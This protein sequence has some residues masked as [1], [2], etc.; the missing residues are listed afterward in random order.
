MARGKS[1]GTCEHCQSQ[2]RYH[3]VHSGFNDSIY[4][5]CNTCG[6]TASL[7]LWDKRM[8]KLRDLQKHQE[9]PS[10]MEPHVQPCVCGGS[11]SRGSAPRCPHCNKP[12]STELATGYIESNAPATWRWQRTWSGLYCIVIEDKWIDDN[13]R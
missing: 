9:I 7:S 5:Y 8:P 10:A 11:F 2:F 12:L 13:F 4:A 6:K 3:L 1:I